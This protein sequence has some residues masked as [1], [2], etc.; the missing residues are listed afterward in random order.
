MSPEEYESNILLVNEEDDDELG[1]AFDYNETLKIPTII[2]E[3]DIRKI[4]ANS[5]NAQEMQ[6]QKSQKSKAKEESY[7]D[8]LGIYASEEKES[9]TID[10]NSPKNKGEKGALDRESE[11]MKELAD[12]ENS[13]DDKF[14]NET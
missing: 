9:Y 4:K 11:V 6:A 10:F 5:K 13:D 12:E 3:D 14:T 2:T 8:N 1:G 7:V